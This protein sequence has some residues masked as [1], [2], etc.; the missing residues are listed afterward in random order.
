MCMCRN[1]VKVDTQNQI[2]S[3]VK[4][5]PYTRTALRGGKGC[6]AL[7]QLVDRPGRPEPNAE[8]AQRDHFRGGGYGKGRE[9]FSYAKD[10]YIYFLLTTFLKKRKNN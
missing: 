8:F 2:S 7:A 3:K 1:F 6:I 4:I 5:Q 10:I 9:V